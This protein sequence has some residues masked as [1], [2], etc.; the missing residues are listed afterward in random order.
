VVRALT[1]ARQRV[2]IH[3]PVEA[4]A[5]NNRRSISRQRRGKQALSTI[6]TVFSVESVQNGH[7]RVEFRSWH[8][9]KNENENSKSIK[10][11]N[12]VGLG[13]V[14]LMY[15][16]VLTVRLLQIRCQDTNCKE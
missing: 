2:A 13:K 1:I 14:D 6:Q 9:W 4:N 5:W 15:Y 12:G 16:V 8:L 3:I 10:E 11:Y 7:K